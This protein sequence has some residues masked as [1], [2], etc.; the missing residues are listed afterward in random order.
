MKVKEIPISIFHT[1]K[2]LTLPVKRLKIKKKEQVPVI[3]S[4][5][6]IPSRLH[7]VHIVIRSVLNQNTSPH[8]IILWL[9]NSLKQNIPKKLTKL[10][11]D[12]FEIRFSDLTCSHRKLIHAL[13]SFPLKIIVTCDDDM[14]YDPNWLRLLYNE[15]KKHP[16]AI[17]ANQTRYIRYGESGELLPYKK[18]VYEKKMPFNENAVL[19]IGV[20]GTLY[21]VGSLSD[22]TTDQNLF[23]KYTPKA[24]D[25]WFKAMSLLKNT[26]SIKAENVPRN[27]TPI[28]G[29]QSESLKKSNIDNNKNHTQWLAVSKYFNLNINK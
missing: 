12:I 27:P 7:I 5:T 15:H 13:E 23:L 22:K 16:N 14:I 19:P 2:L 1:V 24:D 11:G 4:L 26:V 21:P 18:W 25:L 28:I 29:S 10:E 6:S 20:A 3:V 8:K 17:I 9:H